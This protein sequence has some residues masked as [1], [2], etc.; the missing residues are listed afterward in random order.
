MQRGTISAKPS[1]SMLSCVLLFVVLVLCAQVSLANAQ[2]ASAAPKR[3]LV[4]HYYGPEQSITP[5]LDQA[6]Q[7]A[8]RSGSNVDL[9]YYSEYLETYRFPG[10]NYS[11]LLRDFLRQKYAGQD[12]DVIV[13]IFDGALE[14][15]LRYRSDLFPDVP[16]VYLAANRRAEAPNQTGLW[17]GPTKKDTLALA[18]QLARH[19]SRQRVFRHHPALWANRSRHQQ[20]LETRRHREGEVND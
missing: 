13:A 6:L 10:D 16:I 7:V 5:A 19:G 2:E 11:P 17:Q 9:E 12:F 18:R 1:T 15:L 20:E 3:V 8:L 14:F 4:L